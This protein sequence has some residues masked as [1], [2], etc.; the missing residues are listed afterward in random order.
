MNDF[1]DFRS[2]LSDSLE[3]PKPIDLCEGYNLSYAL[4][5]KLRGH[6]HE[7]MSVS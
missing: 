5:V 7:M 4:Y 3:Y 2:V 1:I 6:L